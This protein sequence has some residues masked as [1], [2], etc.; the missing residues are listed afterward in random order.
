MFTNPCKCIFAFVIALPAYKKK[1]WDKTLKGS[2]S[3][4]DSDL[5]FIHQIMI[6][7]EGQYWHG[8]YVALMNPWI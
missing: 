5:E 7:N 8:P 4:S 6:Q 2:D 3:D 1:Q